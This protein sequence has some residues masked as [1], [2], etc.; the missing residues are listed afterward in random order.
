[1]WYLSLCDCG[2]FIRV[3][4]R[5]ATMGRALRLK[6]VRTKNADLWFPSSEFSSSPEPACFCLSSCDFRELTGT[7]CFKFGLGMWTFVSSVGSQLATQKG[8]SRAFKVFETLIT[9]EHR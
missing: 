3:F 1:M 4:A 9:E 6:F 5:V 8:N 7:C 2:F